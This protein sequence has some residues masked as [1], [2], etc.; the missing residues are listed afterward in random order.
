MVKKNDWIFIFWGVKEKYRHV[1][2]AAYIS[3]NIPT[4]TAAQRLS[5][6]ERYGFQ[7]ME[8]GNSSVSEC[9][10]WKLHFCQPSRAD[11]G[12]WRRQPASTPNDFCRREHSS[13]QHCCNIHLL[14]AHSPAWGFSV[15]SLFSWL[16]ASFKQCWSHWITTVNVTQIRFQLPL[17]LISKGREFKLWQILKRPP[18][19]SWHSWFTILLIALFW[20]NVSLSC[21][22]KELM[23]FFITPRSKS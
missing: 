21:S 11:A 17:P 19:K 12:S 6:S 7:Q 20:M 18:A 15:K 8:R 10:G 14:S 13:R 22:L 23:L 1:E 16:H 5:G 4:S 3:W 9:R 2:T